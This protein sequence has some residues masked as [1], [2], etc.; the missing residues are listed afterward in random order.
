MT[1][2]TAK[3]PW[4]WDTGWIVRARACPCRAPERASDIARIERYANARHDPGC[5][6][7]WVYSREPC[8]C[9]GELEDRD[10]VTA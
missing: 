7:G 6:Q 8:D 4:C 3:C 5:N 9:R 1:A 2:R 10:G